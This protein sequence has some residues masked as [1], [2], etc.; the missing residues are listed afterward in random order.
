MRASWKAAAAA[1]L[2]FCSALTAQERPPLD[3]AGLFDVGHLVTDEN[4]D[5]VPDG[6]GAT[7]VLPPDPSTAVLAA[8]TEVAARLG[9]ETSAMNL[10]IPT[11]VDPARV[12]IVFG[13]G[14]WQASALGGSLPSLPAGGAVVLSGRQ[15]T[16]RWV[17]V[18]GGSDAEILDA[19]RM[20]AGSLPHT[21]SLSDPHLRDIATALDEWL[22][23]DS[24]TTAPP[25]GVSFPGARSTEAGLVLEARLSHEDEAGLAR[26]R[27]R[28]DSLALIRS[29]ETLVADS[30]TLRFAGVDTL[31]IATSA[32]GEGL[33]SLP[34]APPPEP[35]G[36]VPGRP[37]SGARND[38]DLSNLFTKDG[39]LADS[40]NNEIPDRIDV[41]LVP[42][43]TGTR[44][45]PALG[46]RLGLE[47]TGLTIPLVRTPDEVERPASQPTMILAG[48][49]HPLVTALADSGRI[50][51]EGEPPG[52]GWI[53][54]LPLAFGEKPSLVITGSDARGAEAAVKYVAESL[55][56][57]SQRREDAPTFR[58]V[59]ED[60]QGLLNAHSPAGQ[61][62]TALY[63]LDRILLDVADGGTPVDPTVLVSVEK[64]EPGLEALVRE[65]LTEAGLGHAQ[66]TIDNRDVQQASVLIDEAVQVPWEVDRFWEALDDQVL[67]NV[68]PGS[69][70]ELEAR[71]SEPPELRATIA[72]EARERLLAAGAGASSSVR[73]LSAF[74]QGFFWL[75]EVIKPA[76][77]EED[78]GEIVISFLENEPPEAWPH[79]AILTP[80]RW[81]HEIYPIDELLARDLGLPLDRIRFEMVEEGP[82]YHVS[83]RAPGGREI[84]AESFEP[85]WVLRPYFDHF[86]DYERVRVTTGSITARIDGTEVVDQRIVTDP[87]WVWDHF[88]ASTLPALYDYVMDRHEGEP[89]GDG[90]DAPYFGELAVEVELS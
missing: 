51:P 14:A 16:Q 1:T 70:V 27:A 82:T 62:A 7:L 83:V 18:G 34:V 84:L 78:V 3:L 66:L 5:G 24:S 73:I 60:L 69:V 57:L 32:T 42:G 31:R 71:L 19:A 90:R 26:A 2:A 48:A 86:D 56:Y 80:L 88:Q 23:P 25:F 17:F 49:A 54:A 75:D 40:D 21:R 30:T 22:R 6:V 45:L 43:G 13:A 81:L 41:V 35:P 15:G 12:A 29:G 28:L 59:E 58:T 36:P 50:A 4:G 68:A 74:K 63:K 77:E 79:Q 89:R 65:R 44:G 37:G 33:V 9:F 87:E 46:A 85:R 61:A 20:L 39:A 38:L 72:R 47:S 52:T 8:A 55:P 11:G 10:P 64:P 67:P 76:L 53:E